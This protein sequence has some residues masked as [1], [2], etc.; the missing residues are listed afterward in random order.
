MIITFGILCLTAGINIGI[1][2]SIWSSNIM[3]K[4]ILKEEINR[5]KTS[6]IKK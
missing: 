1:L 3:E 6:K 4:R 5:N 2:M